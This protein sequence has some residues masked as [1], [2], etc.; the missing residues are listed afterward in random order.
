MHKRRDISSSKKK[1]WTIGSLLFPALT[2]SLFGIITYLLYGM[3]FSNSSVPP[4]NKNLALPSKKEAILIP[5]AY[6]TEGNRFDNVDS[7]V[8]WHGPSGRK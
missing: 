2:F 8:A 4:S 6:I 7:L 1:P 5:E 3:L